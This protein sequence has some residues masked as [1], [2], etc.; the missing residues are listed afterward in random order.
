MPT[1]AKNLRRMSAAQA[2]AVPNMTTYVKFF[3]LNL[4]LNNNNKNNNK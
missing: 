3:V 4:E 1:S 2:T